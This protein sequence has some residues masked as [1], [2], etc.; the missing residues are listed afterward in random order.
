MTWQSAWCLI[1]SLFQCRWAGLP[2]G[3]HWRQLTWQPSPPRLCR[4]Q[5]SQWQPW[6]QDSVLSTGSS[7]TC[8]NQDILQNEGNEKCIKF[9]QPIP[10]QGQMVFICVTHWGIF[11]FG[12]ETY[13]INNIFSII[14]Q[15]QWKIDFTEIHPPLATMSLQRFAHAMTQLLF[16]VQKFG[17]I[18]LLDFGR[19]Q[20]KTSITFE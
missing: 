1:M 19:E 3:R 8:H 2:W 14:I 17:V 10:K 11:L 5:S 7:S 15:I 18:C 6:W 16:Q 20:N 4:K 9:S 12:S 13:F